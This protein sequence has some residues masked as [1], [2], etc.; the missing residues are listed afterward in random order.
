MADGFTTNLNLT[1]P[2]VGASSDT[3]GTKLNAD[4][5]ALD[6]MLL[7]SISGLTLSV[8]G[9]TATFGVAAGGAS[10]MKIAAFTKTTASWALGSGNGALDTG[11]IANSTWYHVWLIQR[12]DTAVVDI[13]LSLSATAPTMPASYDRK[14]LIGSMLTDGSAQWVKFFQLGNDFLWDVPVRTQDSLAPAANTPTLYVQKTPT[15]LKCIANIDFSYGALAGGEVMLLNSPEVAS[16]TPGGIHFTA[17]SQGAAGSGFIFSST[18]YIRTDTSAQI[19][20]SG[21]S[22]ANSISLVT[23]GW[24]HPRGRW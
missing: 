15:G 5:D 20:F 6:A 7:A 23:R 10:G 4:L 14:R 2:E 16:Q 8:A 17:R 3:W 13:L 22:S 24:E 1:K 11:A 12:S 18:T 19:R 21:E 9:S